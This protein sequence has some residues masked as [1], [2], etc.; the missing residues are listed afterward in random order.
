MDSFE[1]FITIHVHV[2]SRHTS[3]WTPQS[4]PLFA[5]WSQKQTLHPCNECHSTVFTSYKYSNTA[6]PYQG[7]GKSTISLSLMKLSRFNSHSNTNNVKLFCL[8]IEV[9][10]LVVNKV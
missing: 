7:N 3:S 4:C 9:K 10:S 5:H 1:G 2:T 8:Y 6:K